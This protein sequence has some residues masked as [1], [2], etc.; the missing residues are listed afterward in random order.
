M[1]NFDASGISAR[2]FSWINGRHG[3]LA[4]ALLLAPALPVGA[5]EI[6]LADAIA[7]PESLSSL[8]ADRPIAAVETSSTE[9]IAQPEQSLLAEI[10][11]AIAGDSQIAGHSQT[12]P[13]EAEVTT[14]VT[15]IET[16]DAEATALFRVSDL[17]AAMGGDDWV[18]SSSAVDLAQVTRVTDFSDV[19]PSDWA[20]QALSSL[21]ESYGCIQGYPDRTFRGQRSLTRFEF[22]AGL[23][24]CMDVLVGSLGSISDEDLVAIRRLQDEFAA[25]LALLEGRVDVLEA[26]VAQLRAQQFSTQ[27]KLR[28]QVFA[29]VGGGFANGPIQAEGINIFAAARD[30]ITGL[31]QV[32]TVDRNPGT[33]IGSLAWIN[34]DTS[35]TGS[36][37]LKLQFVAGAGVGPANLYGSAGLFNTFG[38]PF[39]FQ[40]GGPSN[41]D[42][43]V[44]ELSYMFPVGDSLTIDIGPRINWYSYFDNNR[45]T[46]FLTGANSFNSSGG[47]QVNS[48]DRG[49]GVIAVWDVTDWLDVRVGYLAESTEFIPGLRTAE[50][51]TLGLFG[52]TSTL[53]G[54]IGIQP[55][56]S[57]N[58]RFL[59]T[60]SNLMPN[61]AGQI[62]GTFSEPI[63]GFADD[64]FGGGLT[65]A[66][67]DTFLVNFDWAATNW[68]GFFGR[69]SYGST[70]LTSAVTRTRVGDVNAQSFQL[71]VAFPNLFKEGALATVSYLVPFDVTGGRN[72][73]VS[74]GGDGGTQQELE[75]SYRYPLS[76][77]IA[78]MPSAY[79]IMNA[80]NFGNNPDI[81]L[82]NLQ[83]QISF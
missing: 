14:E 51:P 70:K 71:G 34:M 13:L 16:L 62:G 78:L 47:T 21:V 15:T 43:V 50:N 52:G 38:T 39:T 31:P 48:L 46:F 49:S 76:R 69:Y 72:F 81:F 1:L 7:T 82:F 57:L 42:V 40:T 73:L 30:P 23:N 45:Y 77:N 41:F 58:L 3:L 75:L 64:G 5:T 44:R 33:T 27:T 83:A 36:D 63:Y 10:P 66:P 22:A 54:Q 80:N 74:G 4:A 60:R 11:T 20:F 68:L 79:W 28:G 9:G 2:L 61:A 53:T 55:F 12:E 18:Q 24:A 37:R 25:E 6:A 19:L 35:F 29:H 8:S 26:D 32:R 17:E 65:N 67:A 59:Y 56:D